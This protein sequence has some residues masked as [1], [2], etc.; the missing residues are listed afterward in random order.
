MHTYVVCT[1]NT[2]LSLY[3]HVQVDLLVR[4]IFGKFACEKQ[5]AN[6]ILAIQ[7]TMSFGHVHIVINTVQDDLLARN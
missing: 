5:L 6:F 7:A 4:V 2:I 1:C 3:N